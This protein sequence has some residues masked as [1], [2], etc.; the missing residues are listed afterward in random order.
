[1][2]KVC[3]DGAGWD[4]SSCLALLICANGALVREFRMPLL[5]HHELEGSVTMAL[6]SAAQ[7]RLDPVM[8]ANGVVEAQRV[9]LVGVFLMSILRCFSKQLE[10]ARA[11]S[12]LAAGYLRIPQ[13]L[14]T[15]L[16]LKRA[17]TGLVGSPSRSS[18]GTGSL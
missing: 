4:S 3:L 16:R 9:F 18:M 10:S 7:K 12:P 11:S 2:R 5:E 13:S 15:L 6:F 17:S 8:L 1:M 14:V